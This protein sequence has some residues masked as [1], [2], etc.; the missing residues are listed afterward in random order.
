MVA[1]FHFTLA[2]VSIATLGMLGCQSQQST[3]MANFDEVYSLPGTDKDVP[4]NMKSI[5]LSELAKEGVLKCDGLDSQSKYVYTRFEIMDHSVK[6]S[7][8]GS[9]SGRYQIFHDELLSRIKSSKLDFKGEKSEIQ[10]FEQ[11][12]NQAFLVLS[13]AKETSEARDEKIDA[14]LS[15]ENKGHE[16]DY[17]K[18]ELD[19]VSFKHLSL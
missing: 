17:K 18:I 3:E 5:S 16:V 11:G 15:Y 13:L 9:I 12:S 7:Y 4:E 10:F 6:F 8:V 2:I 19:C 1:G 14:K